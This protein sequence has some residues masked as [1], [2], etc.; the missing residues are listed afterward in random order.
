MPFWSYQAI[1]DGRHELIADNLLNVA[2]FIPIGLLFAMVFRSIRCWI[3]LL[4][5]FV[6]SFIIEFLQFVLNR[7]NAEIDDVMHNVLGSL[8]GYGFYSLIK[9]GVEKIYKQRM[10]VL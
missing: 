6:I 9:Y 7:G 8:I 5:G 4:G 10:A 2:I 3:V 1:L